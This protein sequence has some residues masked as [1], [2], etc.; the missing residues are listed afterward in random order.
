[1]GVRSASLSSLP[2]CKSQNAHS[3]F[4]ISL[5]AVYKAVQQTDFWERAKS[6]TPAAPIF[7]DFAS[8]LFACK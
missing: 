4:D 2:L 6:R 3:D 5:I 7:T 8:G 1:M